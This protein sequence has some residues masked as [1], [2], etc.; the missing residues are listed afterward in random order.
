MKEVMG[1]NQTEAADILDRA[2]TRYQIDSQI[3]VNVDGSSSETE[4]IIASSEAVGDDTAS[5]NS[6]ST[7][8]GECG[9][10]TYWYCDQMSV[11]RC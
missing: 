1:V 9:E 7:D 5:I 2:D 11:I 10:G 6:E 8:G 3:S 4:E